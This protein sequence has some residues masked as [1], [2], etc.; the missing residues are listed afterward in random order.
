MKRQKQG[1]TKRRTKHQSLPL[2]KKY[3]SFI[4]VFILKESPTFTQDVKNVV[5]NLDERKEN[6]K[7][8]LASYPKA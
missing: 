7:P 6:P 5:S 1:G 8:F 4:Q 2:T 3:G